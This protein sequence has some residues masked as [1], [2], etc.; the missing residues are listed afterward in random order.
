MFSEKLVDKMKD[1]VDFEIIPKTNEEYISVTYASIRFIDSYRFQSSSLDSLL[2]T[3]VDNSIK[4]LKD[5]EEEIVDNNELLNIVSEIK[6][7]DTEDKYKNDSIKDLKKDYPNEIEKLEEA[8]HNYMGENDLKILKTGFPNKW[9]YLT[10]KLA[11]PYEFFNCIEDY[12]KPV[13][14]LTNEDFFSKLKN[15]C[16]DYEEIERTKENIKIF[17]IKNGEQ[18]T[19]I[20]L[21]SD[22]LLL[23]CVSEKFIKVSVNEF[24]I[25]PLYCVSLPGYTWEC[26]LKYTGIN[27]QTL[28]D[29]DLILTL[30]NNIR[31]GISTVCGD[32]YVKS[33]EIKK[34]L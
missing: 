16:P 27:L 10:K 12:Q 3:L 23:A 17:D 13:D 31:G 4:T 9:K 2:K 5:F 22:V 6:M 28:Q 21:K 25:N 26:G 32:W 24:D 8:L 34:I 29:K 18:L 14:K 30:E 1:K 11:Y 33:D 15:I 7:L 20:Y 19:Q